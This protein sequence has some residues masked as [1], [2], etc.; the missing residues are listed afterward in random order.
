MCLTCLSHLSA[1]NKPLLVAIASHDQAIVSMNE[2]REEALA[3]KEE[4][5]ALHQKMGSK[6]AKDI[7]K[8]DQD[9]PT[10]MS[11]S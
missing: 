5:E 2:I 10:Q 3:L 7:D 4:A 9:G 8:G 1:A 11:I 6:E